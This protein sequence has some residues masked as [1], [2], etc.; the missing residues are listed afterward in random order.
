MCMTWQKGTERGNASN[1]GLKPRPQAEQEMQLRLKN[2]SPGKGKRYKSVRGRAILTKSYINREENGK[3]CLF[4]TEPVNR[5][6]C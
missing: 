3:G 6:P 1:L 4:R 5:I 2:G